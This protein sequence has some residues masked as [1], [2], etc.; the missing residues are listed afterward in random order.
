MTGERRRFDYL[1][2]GLLRRV[3]KTGTLRVDIDDQTVT[4][5]GRPASPSATITIHQPQAL[6]ARVLRGGSV[7]FA[8]AYIDGLWDTPDLPGLLELAA[9]NND[10]RRATASGWMGMRGFRRLWRRLFEGPGGPALSGMVDHYNLGNDFY[11]MW[12]DPSMSYSSARFGGDDD[13]EAAQRRK[14]EDITDLAG[15]RSGDRVL[16]IGCGWGAMA[17]FLAVELGC[18][19]TAVTNSAQHHE[20][21]SRRM[22]EA[23]VEDRVEV[24]LGDFRDVSGSFDRVISVEMIE[25]IDEQQWPDLYEVIERSLVPGGIAALQVITID[26]DLHEEMVGRDDFIRSYIFPGGALP[27]IRILRHLGDAA[28]LEWIRYTE[29]GASYAKTLA[30]WEQRFIDA[31]PRIE[32]SLDGFDDRFNRMWR[33]YLAYCQAGFRTGRI[34]GIQVAYRKSK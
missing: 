10:A 33:Y 4:I 16:E 9:R 5:S 28:G 8:G 17:E 30:V 13:L 14:Y 12:L 21:A 32:A 2:L 20:F 31:W 1:M 24:V 18:S 11:A 27:S 34:D 26:H 15:I 22:K 3:L 7:G 23:G 25:S 6:A 29:H 19:V